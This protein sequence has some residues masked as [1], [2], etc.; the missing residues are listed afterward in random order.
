MLNSEISKLL[1][2]NKKTIAVAESCTGGL[3]SNSLTNI[4]GSSKYF[5]L[6][7][8]LYSNSAKSKLL[9]INK[10]DI[11][12]FGVVSEKVAALMAKKVKT[13][14]GAHIGLATTG[15]AGSKGGNKNNPIG[16]VYVALAYKNSAIVKRWNFSGKRTQIKNK[17]KNKALSLIKQCLVNP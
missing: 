12:R 2:K 7:L 11:S 14:A 16:T 17:A 8:V 6:G 10:K 3:I 9:K 15:F 5:K 4:N 1:L 13:L